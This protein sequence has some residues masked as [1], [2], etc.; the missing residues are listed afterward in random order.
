LYFKT[1]RE[2]LSEL[3]PT[4][5]TVRAY[6]QKQLQQHGILELHHLLSQ[7]D[8]IGAARLKPTDTQR[9]LRALEMMELTGKTYSS[10]LS[11]PKQT[12]NGWEFLPLAIQPEDR[13]SL[14]EQ[15]KLRFMK[16]L[17]LGFLKEVERLIQYLQI[18][19]TLNLDLPSLRIV[20][21]RQ[22]YL[23][24]QQKITYQEFVDQSIA[25]TR[26]LAKRQITWLRADTQKQVVATEILSDLTKNKLNSIYSLINSFMANT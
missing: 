24:L 2:G 12:R 15:I 4:D 8:P 14:H 16:M 6:W 23:Y 26:Q 1:L 20:G 25:A 21:Y 22:A 19:G 11:Q 18:Q 3:P 17:E 9:I 13:L 7:K 10:L 5:S